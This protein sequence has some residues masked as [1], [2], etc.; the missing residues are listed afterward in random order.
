MILNFEW[1]IYN[2]KCCFPEIEDKR[3]HNVSGIHT[4]WR[5]WSIFIFC[6]TTK[7][8]RTLLGRKKNK[9]DK[10][11]DF[12]LS[13]TFAAPVYRNSIYCRH[14]HNR[15]QRWTSNRKKQKWKTIQ[16]W[17]FARFVTRTKVYDMARR[18]DVTKIQLLALWYYHYDTMLLVLCFIFFVRNTRTRPR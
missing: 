18:R 16:V 11:R 9:Y 3:Y 6:G 15:P 1:N 10:E 12:G 14:Y 4:L 5:L 17:Q 7:G 13:R 8:S 2:P